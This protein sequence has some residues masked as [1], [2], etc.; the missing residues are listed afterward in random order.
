MIYPRKITSFQ[1]V[2][3]LLWTMKK[4][5]ANDLLL[6]NTWRFRFSETD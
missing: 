2:K 6:S 5:D 1:L 4:M 3:I